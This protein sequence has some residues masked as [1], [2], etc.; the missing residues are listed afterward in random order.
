[1]SGLFSLFFRR[2][3]GHTVAGRPPQAPQPRPD[4]D[5]P[6]I[7]VSGAAMS[8]LVLFPLS[9]FFIFQ[10][11]GWCLHSHTHSLLRFFK[12]AQRFFFFF[13]AAIYFCAL[14]GGAQVF[15]L[16]LLSGT[17]LRGAP[18]NGP[19]DQSHS[20]QALYLLSA[21]WPHALCCVQRLTALSR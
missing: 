18:G 16:A 19:P 3:G 1:M 15:L 10:M 13:F 9:L 21:L 17:T 8:C 6:G 20:R 2:C 5:P 7:K 12:N 11:I 14:P 4:P